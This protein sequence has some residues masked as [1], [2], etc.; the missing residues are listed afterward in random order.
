MESTTKK[1]LIFIGIPVVLSLGFVAFCMGL[2]I[3]IGIT[4]N[5]QI[6]EL[7]KKQT[8]ETVGTVYDASEN[9]NHDSS[10]GGSIS[11]VLRYEYTVNGKSYTGSN[12]SC[13]IR[14]GTKGKVCYEPSDPNNS[15][16]SILVNEKCSGN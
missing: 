7:R 9:F 6:G 15:S 2:V 16:F 4:R 13:A 1:L 12:S 10:G 8:A 5:N 3:Y 14:K 11:C